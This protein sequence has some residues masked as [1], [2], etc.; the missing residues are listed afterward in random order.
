MGI[1]T[2]EVDGSTFKV[3]KNVR[4]NSVTRKDAKINWRMHK[5]LGHT[6]ELRQPVRGKVVIDYDVLV[7][8][9]EAAYFPF[10][11]KKKKAK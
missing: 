5:T 7:P 10:V 9:P 11:V 2:I 3:G 6:V 1:R 4:V 8:V